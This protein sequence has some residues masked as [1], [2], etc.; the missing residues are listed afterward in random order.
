MTK[1]PYLHSKVLS[2]EAEDD[3][4]GTNTLIVLYKIQKSVLKRLKKLQTGYKAESKMSKP[5]VPVTRQ[6]QIS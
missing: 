4:T 5:W 3:D 1:I 2:N 6:T